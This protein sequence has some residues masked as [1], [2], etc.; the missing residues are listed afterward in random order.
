MLTVLQPLNQKPYEPATIKGIEQSE[1]TMSEKYDA[2]LRH[3]SGQDKQ[4][5]RTPVKILGTAT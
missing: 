3:A 2:I 4:K 5:Q 1:Q